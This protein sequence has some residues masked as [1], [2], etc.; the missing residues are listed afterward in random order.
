[1]AI[2]AIALRPRKALGLFDAA[3]NLCAQAVDVFVLTL[4]AGALL[5]Y[6]TFLTRDAVL[7]QRSVLFPVLL[8]TVSLCL[9]S[10]GLAAASHYAHALLM[11]AQPPSL[12]ASLTQ[13]LRRLPTLIFAT[14]YCL[15]LNLL[16]LT[17]TGGIA[18]LFINA[19]VVAYAVTVRGTLAGR[20]F[21]L[22]QVC[23]EQLGAAKNSAWGLRLFGLSALLLF[24]N[25]HLATVLMLTLGTKVLGADLTFVSRF[26]SLDNDTWVFLLGGITFVLFEPLR[27]CAA[28]LLLIDGRVREE[29]FDLLAAVEQLPKRRKLSVPLSVTVALCLLPAFTFAD[30]ELVKRTLEA[31]ETCKVAVSKAD[32]EL[33]EQTAAQTPNSLSRFVSSL[34]T[35]A[36]DDEDCDTTETLLLEGVQWMRQVQDTSN[37]AQTENARLQAERIL[38]APEFLDVDAVKDD[39]PP[40]D[41]GDEDSWFKRF[42][43]WLIEWLR[44]TKPED[45]DEKSKVKIPDSASMPGASTVMLVAAVATLAALAL[46]LWR[47]LKT[48]N[49]QTAGATVSVTENSAAVAQSSALDNTPQ[50]WAGLA[51]SYANQGQFRDAI[52][53]LYLALLSHFHHQ[54]VIHYDPHVSNWEYLLAFRGP[55]EFKRR[56]RELTHRFDFAW[57]GDE[58]VTDDAWNSFRQLA[59][60]IFVEGPPS[61][62]AMAV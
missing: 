20:P 22:Y 27:A 28:T 50:G 30:S 25:L 51:D 41:K 29:G 36:Y 48:P 61:I 57:Y 43:K 55:S 40:E 37:S 45:R 23:A 6:A 1:M 12:M 19:H 2:D 14:A 21:S 60:P 5:L 4:P 53:H 49:Q 58:T 56:F 42:L 38:Q 17:F 52:R 15:T 13:S 26:C 44:N 9:R 35:S 7:T 54:G 47:L 62:K 46:V 24:I 3:L 10:V 8:A 33:L 32:V 11:D 59:E 34:E 18:L 39:K 16:I 31:A